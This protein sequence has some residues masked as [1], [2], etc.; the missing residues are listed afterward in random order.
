METNKCPLCGA[1]AKHYL[2]F[3]NKDYHR[4]SNC[5]SIFMDP[6]SYLTSEEE[7]ARYLL[8]NNDINNSGYQNFVKP[9]IEY[10]INN[11]SQKDQGLDFGAGNGPVIAS[12]LKGKDYKIKLFDPFFHNQK[13]LLKEKYDYIISCEVIEHFHHP[14]EEFKMLKS[15]LNSR[16]ELILKTD[17]LK[18]EVNFE[19]WYYKNDSTHVFFYSEDTF[20]YIMKKYDFCELIIDDRLIILKA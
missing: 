17:I 10:T 7:K 6:N 5:N 20:K 1:I 18:P 15:M 9:L 8:H 16:G 2:K 4:C 19:K 3:R 11:F 14:A 13:E 12:I